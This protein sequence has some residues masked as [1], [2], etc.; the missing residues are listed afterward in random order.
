M[1]VT[2]RLL[3][4]LNLF[5]TGLLLLVAALT[6]SS[7]GGDMGPQGLPG[8]GLVGPAG[9]DAVLEVIELCP[10]IEGDGFKEHLFKINDELFGVYSDKKRVFLVKL[11]RGRAYV[12]T[13]GRDCQFEVTETGEV[14]Q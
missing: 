6:L 13:D 9:A 7:C 2:N 11:L 5:T 10:E 8:V 14:L 12:T 1:K 4:S 3:L